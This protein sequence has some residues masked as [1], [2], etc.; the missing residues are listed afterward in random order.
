MIV[1]KVFNQGN[2]VTSFIS[3]NT[4]EILTQFIGD[5]F[6]FLYDLCRYQQLTVVFV[7]IKI[8]LQK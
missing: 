7:L 5:Q 8:T 4:T 2:C 6:I 1:N 3:Q